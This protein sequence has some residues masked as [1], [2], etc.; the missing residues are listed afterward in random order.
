LW[1]LSSWS[2]CNVDLFLAQQK[3][4]NHDDQALYPKTNIEA[5]LL[6]AVFKMGFKIAFIKAGFGHLVG[7]GWMKEDGGN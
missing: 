1:A 4:E 3:Y 2:S 7:L 6:N 5:N